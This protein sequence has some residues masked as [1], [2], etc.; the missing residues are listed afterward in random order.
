MEM[1][2]HRT[3]VTGITPLAVAVLEY[4]KSIIDIHPGHPFKAGAAGKCG[5]AD[6]TPSTELLKNTQAARKHFT[7]HRNVPDPMEVRRTGFL[8]LGD[9]S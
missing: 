7:V 4:G 2:L 9:S 6:E 1:N 8:S 5:E 3:T